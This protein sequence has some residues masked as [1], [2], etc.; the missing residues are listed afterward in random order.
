MYVLYPASLFLFPQV[1]LIISVP[2][3]LPFSFSQKWLKINQVLEDIAISSYFPRKCF[4]IQSWRNLLFNTDHKWIK[5][6]GDVPEG[7]EWSSGETG[8]WTALIQDNGHYATNSY[9]RTLPTNQTVSGIKSLDPIPGSA[10]KPRF[11][12]LYEYPTE[13]ATRTGKNSLPQNRYDCTMTM[14][15]NW[16]LEC[17]NSVR[18]EEVL[19][20]SYWMGRRKMVL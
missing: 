11:L 6:D 4:M 1:F 18:S 3:P 16:D 13:M 12:Q 5:P 20:R 17:V 19:S 15:Y 9:Y 8:C 14:L 2:F 10:E 7:S